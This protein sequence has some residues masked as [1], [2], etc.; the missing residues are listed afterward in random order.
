MLT[1]PL[2]C[3]TVATKQGLISKCNRHPLLGQATT[4]DLVDLIRYGR[5]SVQHAEIRLN[6]DATSSVTGGSETALLKVR[7]SSGRW[8]GYQIAS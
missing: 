1:S 7:A 6:Q 3:D 5:T 2:P 4:L 8:T